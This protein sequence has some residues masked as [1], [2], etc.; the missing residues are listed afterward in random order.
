LSAAL[1]AT[2]SA[3]SHSAA[4][5]TGVVPAMLNDWL[6]LVVASTW[7]GGLLHFILVMLPSLRALQSDR[8]GHALATLIRRFSALALSAV[9]ALGVTGL[10]SSWLHAGSIEALRA[11]AY[12]QTLLLKLA[13]IVLLLVPAA[14]HLFYWRGRVAARESA[15]QGFRRTLGIEIILGVLV[16]AVAGMLAG[17]GP[18]R[19]AL[20]LRQAEAL[21]LEQAAGPLHATVAIRPPRPGP[22]EF[23][24]RLAE[25]DGQPYE[26][27][28]RVRLQFTPANSDLGGSDIT[29]EPRG[30]GRFVAEGTYLSLVG[31]WQLELQVQR[32]DGE[33]VFASFGLDV[34]ENAIQAQAS[35]SSG[36]RASEWLAWGLLA[37]GIALAI[38]AALLPWQREN[39]VVAWC[40][41][42][43]AILLVVTGSLQL[44]NVPAAAG[45]ATNPVPP[46]SASTARGMTLFREHCQACH[47]ES[48]EGDGVQAAALDSPAVNLHLHVPRY[49]DRE[50]YERITHG[51]PGAMH[52]FG[53][54]I[55]ED[56]RWHLVNYL[57]ALMPPGMDH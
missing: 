42:G 48:G 4:V 39:R 22:A 38:Y 57:R 33:D 3:S 10:F 12:G 13:L 26:N 17:L 37:G 34:G 19:S 14:V 55:P 1:L 21:T 44:A 56:D 49:S 15:R 43:L 23:E 40:I 8:R 30:E 45:S 29:A 31:E 16:L 6:H 36:L 25:A 20:E 27:A 24:V 50:I 52:D 46:T 53:A 18:A 51:I 41:L 7:I 28:R 2:I 47:G 54:A 32:L 5:E 9:V 11:T 35:D